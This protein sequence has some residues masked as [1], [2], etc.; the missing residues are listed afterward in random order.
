VAAEKDRE[1]G[2][3]VTKKIK[4]EEERLFTLHTFLPSKTFFLVFFRRVCM[5]ACVLQGGSTPSS[6]H[7]F[8]FSLSVLLICI[9]TS[10]GKRMLEEIASLCIF[11]LLDDL[12]SLYGKEIVT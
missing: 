5:C 10:L 6:T 2:W 8:L 4:S 1:G 9:G 12:V 3:G 11:D 7:L